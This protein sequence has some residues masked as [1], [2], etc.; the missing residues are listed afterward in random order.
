MPMK[1]LKERLLNTDDASEKLSRSFV[2]T[3]GF[4]FSQV[5]AK[6]T[7]A[8]TANMMPNIT[9]TLRYML[10]FRVSFIMSVGTSP[11]RIAPT[12]DQIILRL[13]NFERI[14]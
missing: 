2:L 4:T 12:V 10:V 3:G 6:V 5:P 1:I 11:A 8:A 9:A 13:E 7:I 14:S